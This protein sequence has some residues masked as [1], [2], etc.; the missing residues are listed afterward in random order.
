MKDAP[1]IV[2]LDGCIEHLAVAM[3]KDGVDYLTL[4]K[5]ATGDVVIT[6]R[7]EGKLVKVGWVSAVNER[8]TWTDTNPR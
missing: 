6:V 4:S 8:V 5:E 3:N 7:R 1:D 2:E